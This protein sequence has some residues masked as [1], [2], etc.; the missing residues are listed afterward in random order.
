MVAEILEVLAPSPAR[1]RSIKFLAMAATPRKSWPAFRP[2]ADCSA[3]ILI[4]IEPAQDRSAT[5]LVR[6]WARSV[7][8]ASHPAGLQKVPAKAGLT[9][10]DFILADLGVSSMQIDDPSRGFSTKQAGPHLTCG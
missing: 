4:R 9:G 1:S 2:A 3:S 8:R 6:L 5:A 10:A 7:Q